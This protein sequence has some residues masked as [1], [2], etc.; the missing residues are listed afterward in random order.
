MVKKSAANPV[1]QQGAVMVCV[2]RQRTCARLI[3][4]GEEQAQRLGGPL[5]I[6][7]AVGL[8]DNFLGNPYE[9]EALEYL[10]TAAQLANGE[11]SVLRSDQ[12]ATALYEYAKE[13]DVRCIVMGAS[14]GQQNSHRVTVEGRNITEY[15]Q[16]RLPDVEFAII[17]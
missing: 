3:Q 15:L 9:G 10:F 1:E 8:S 2:T 13:H 11:L 7:H 17:D 12:V 4:A 14:P 6:V 16:E 5:Y